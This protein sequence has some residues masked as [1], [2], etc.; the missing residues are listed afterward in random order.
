L[1]QLAR[2]SISLVA[3]DRHADD[4]VALAQVHAAYAAGGA[5]HR[6]HVALLEAD[7]HAPGRGQHDVPRP[8][9]QARVDQL[10]VLLDGGGDDA[11][12]AD[13]RELSRAWSA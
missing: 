13:V 6:P 2:S 10:V 5:P 8:G 4:V 12:R 9:G 1:R 7:R 3:E 11:G